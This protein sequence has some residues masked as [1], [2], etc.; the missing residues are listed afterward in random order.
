MRTRGPRRDVAD[1]ALA[2]PV[3][4]KNNLLDDDAAAVELNGRGCQSRLVETHL[5]E[6]YNQYSLWVF[7]GIG[8]IAEDIV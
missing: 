7:C 5:Y 3:N 8:C 2:M 4:Q 1:V 6:L